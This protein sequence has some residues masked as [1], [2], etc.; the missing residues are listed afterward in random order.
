MEAVF[1]WMELLP[2][3][4]H[5]TLGAEISAVRLF[6]TLLYVYVLAIIQRLTLTGANANLHHLYHSV[7]AAFLLYYN[8]GFTSSYF[9]GNIIIIYV[10]IV[11][12]KSSKYA[13]ILSLIVNLGIL[14][15]GYVENL[16]S[17]GSYVISWTT[18]HCVL[19][20]KLIGLTWDI[21]DG[22]QQNIKGKEETAVASIPTFLEVLG[23]SYY[24]PGLMT[25]PQISFMKYKRF[26]EGMF[27][28]HLSKSWVYGM[29]RLMA[30]LVFVIGYPVIGSH[31]PVSYFYTQQYTE[32]PLVYRL[33]YMLLWGQIVLARY[34]GVWLVAEGSCVISGIA[35]NGVDNSGNVK[36]N[37]CAN[38]KLST[39]LTATSL[40]HFV[41]SFN[42]NTNK[43]VLNYVYKRLRFLN[44]KQISQG[45]ALLF[46]A[47]WHGFNSGYFMC[48]FLEF[49]FMNG[50]KQISQLCEKKKLLKA[51]VTQPA[52][53][54]LIK[55][56]TKICATFFLSYALI[57]FDQLQYSQY[58]TVGAVTQCADYCKHN[59]K[60]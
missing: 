9:I 5:E 12:F 2:Q 37:A 26:T 46:L 18:A 43:W 31:L 20:L 40:Q 38:I 14:G 25:G 41:D 50:E 15:V 7:T 54:V 13:V 47:A 30:G 58:I 11:L 21:Y 17:D 32:D 19:T 53:A 28:Q 49:V 10:I 4:L 6:S 34:V 42:I 23:F 56:F 16:Y 33:G 3:R 22:A 36:W 29:S 39:Y 60:W 55:L 24:P 35:F 59:V 44:N 51:I 52:L 57:S 1:Y 8:F 27:D 45:V 48:F